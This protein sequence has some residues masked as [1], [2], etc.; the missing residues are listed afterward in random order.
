MNSLATLFKAI[1]T[2]ENKQQLQ[3]IVVPQIGSHFAAKRYRLFFLDSLPLKA[4]SLFKKAISIQHN[5]VLRYVV[6]HHAP[7]HERVLMSKLEWQAICPRLDHGHVMAG[8]IVNHSKLIGGLGVTRDRE[9]SHRHCSSKEFTTQDMMDMSALCLHIS[10][11]LAKVESEQTK[12][13]LNKSQL[14]TPREA[15]IAELVAKGLTNAEIGQ[16]LWITENT[17]KQALKR[18]FRKLNVSSRAAMVAFLVT[19]C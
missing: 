2:T 11:H 14:I 16:S 15:E 5:P 3:Q 13:T 6:E 8:A 9:S 10:T 7:V 18:I 12:I 1:A 17:V 19:D 4:S